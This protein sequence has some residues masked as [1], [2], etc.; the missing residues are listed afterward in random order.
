MRKCNSSAAYLA[1]L[2]VSDILFLLLSIGNELQYPWM[3]GALDL[4]G[5]CQIWNVLQMTTQYIS[6]LLV[7]AFTVE[8]FISVWRPFS[9]EKLSKNSRSPKII[10]AII[11]ISVVLASPQAVFWNVEPD[12]GECG[13]RHV[14]SSTFNNFYVIWNW[15]SELVMFGAVP[16]IAFIL[17]LCVLRQIRTVGKLYVTSKTLHRHVGARC[18]PTTATL[19]WISF[20]LIFSKLPVTIVF[21]LQSSIQLGEPMSL[22]DMARDP[23]WQNY[24]TYFTARKLIEE[25]GISHHA[26]NIF[27]YAATSKQFRCHLKLMLLQLSWCKCRGFFFHSSSPV[28]ARPSRPHPWN[29]PRA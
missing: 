29:H 2:A 18:T 24:L 28:T 15:T 8:R 1:T 14:N 27:I 16:I 5:W 20:Y 25:L 19:M 22:E 23:T 17:N 21:T 3:V 11:I 12:I 26:C 9:C 7:F 4:Q 13:V 10:V 6:L